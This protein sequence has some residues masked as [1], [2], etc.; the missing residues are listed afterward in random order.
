VRV[1]GLRLPRCLF[2]CLC[3]LHLASSLR[4]CSSCPS[5]RLL[6]LASSLI[7]RSRRLGLLALCGR[8]GLTLLPRSG[9]LLLP[10][11]SLCRLGRPGLPC[12]RSLCSR[13]LGLRLLRRLFRCLCLLHLAR[14]LRLCSSCLSLRLLHLLGSLLL[15]S[16]RLSLLAACGCRQLLL[17][18][19]VG[20]LGLL[21]CLLRCLRLLHLARSLR[22]CSSC[23]SLRLLHLLGSPLLGSLRLSLLAACGCRQLLLLAP[24]GGL[25]LLCCLLQCLRLLH[26]ARSL[27]LCSSGPSLGI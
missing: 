11:S 16:L 8:Q 20:G 2:R 9:G 18:V 17:L 13:C 24:V 22:L 4:L 21:R 7:L 10:S 19:R 5:L 12:G 6:H 23:L 27:C 3:L 15:G 26:L 1:G 25:R 14:G